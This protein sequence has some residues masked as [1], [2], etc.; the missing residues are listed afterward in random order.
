[1]T[2]EETIEKLGKMKMATMAKSIRERLSKPDHQDLSHQEMIGLIIDDE[3]LARENR[4]MNRRLKN[5]KFKIIATMEGIDYQIKRGLIKNKMLELGNLK[6]IIQKQNIIITGPTGAGK[7]FVAQALAHH[8]CRQ[9][10]TARY[11]RLTK[12]LNELIVSRADGTYQKLLG[13]LLKYD[14]LI[15]DD[16]GIAPLQPQE[17]QDL[18]EVID[19][20]YETRST[21]ITS[22]LP[23]K[24]WHEFI[25]N[26]TVADALC[27]R[28]V[29]N[30]YKIKLNGK[31]SVR[32]LKGGIKN[33][34]N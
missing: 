11:S 25:G 21:I 7:S 28:L 13:K 5:A 33:E 10:Y 26:D 32:K 3:Y 27:D 22:Q 30:A 2:I 18:L 20:R 12:L 31:D 4:K 8:A 19:D 29:H 34:E 14:V 15:L 23:A 17:Q 24:N 16:W 9:G 1:M 6:W